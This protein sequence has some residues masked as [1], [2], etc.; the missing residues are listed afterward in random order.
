ME[1]TQ[2]KRADFEVVATPAR[3]VRA[4]G[5][6]DATGSAV[7]CFD[8]TAHEMLTAADGRHL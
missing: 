2:E 1:G 4:Y 8:P 3:L 6:S 7:L 5:T